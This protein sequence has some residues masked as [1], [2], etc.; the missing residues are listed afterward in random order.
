VAV[1]ED[2]DRVSHAVVDA[3]GALTQKTKET[4]AASFETV[5]TNPEAYS[6]RHPGIGS[7]ETMNIA[8]SASDANP[9]SVI[10]D[11]T[12]GENVQGDVQQSEPDTLVPFQIIKDNPKDA[13]IMARD[14][15]Q[16]AVFHLNTFTT[17]ETNLFRVHFL[18]LLFSGLSMRRLRIWQRVP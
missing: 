14:G 6:I 13:A 10:I 15:Q 4:W 1:T 9:T 7:A 17:Y 12:R 5:V 11:T 16:I 2:G 18:A 8:S 3:V